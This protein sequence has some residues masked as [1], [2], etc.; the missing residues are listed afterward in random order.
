[1]P[2][3]CCLLNKGSEQLTARA[4]EQLNRAHFKHQSTK[5]CAT[6]AQTH[7]HTTLWLV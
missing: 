6:H 5:A 4:A 2:F 3:T 7:T 1:M